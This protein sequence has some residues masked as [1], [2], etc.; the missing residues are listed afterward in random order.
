MS[1][2]SRSFSLGEPIAEHARRRSLG[3]APEGGGGAR[4][5]PRIGG[6]AK[7][8]GGPHNG[9]G[10]APGGPRRGGE[11]LGDPR[12]GGGGAPGDERLGDLASITQVTSVPLYLCTPKVT[13]KNISFFHLS[14]MRC[15]RIKCASDDEAIVTA[16]VTAALAEY[17][18]VAER[19]PDLLQVV[20]VMVLVPLLE[21]EVH[22]DYDDVYLHSDE[23]DYTVHSVHMWNQSGDIQI[24]LG[25]DLTP[26]RAAARRT[27]HGASL[28]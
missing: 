18:S 24:L 22:P 6:G 9:G 13:P 26:S 27:A 7:P 25:P 11:A 5:D 4:G 12:I 16:G 23:R 19:F 10:G 20:H 14:F 8:M 3:G 21:G 15:I 17:V 1:L 28:P 2:I